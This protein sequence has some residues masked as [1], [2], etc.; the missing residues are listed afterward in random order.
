VLTIDGSMGEGGGQV[1]RSSL[2]LSLATGQPLRMTR[3]RAGRKKPGLLQQHLTAVR[4]AGEVG[5]A[6]V[7]GAAI[8]STE[9]TFEPGEVVPGDY[10]FAVGTAGSATLVLQTVLPPLLTAS[11]PSQLTLEGGTHNSWAPPFPFLAKAFLPLIQHTGPRVVARLDR[12][13]FYPAGG[14]RFNVSIQPTEELGRIELLQR[15]EVRHRRAR[16]L[17]ARL[18][19]HVAERELKVVAGRLRLPKD[20]LRIEEVTDSRG[21]GNVLMIEVECEHVTELFT[22]FG[23][24]GIRAEAVA[25]AAVEECEAY[26]DADVPV[27]SHLADQLLI[28]MAMAGGGAF[29][30]VTPSRHM[31]TNVEVLKQFLDVDVQVEKEGPDAWCVTVRRG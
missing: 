3:I 6:K 15:G 5:R 9:L 7:S 19:R 13:G 18:P 26:L 20:A 10:H 17:V 30:T 2:T 8:G 1:L 16:A 29:R 22:G 14:G 21:P 28:P 4:A 24:R 11:G 12:P 25:R 23:R 31:T 27:G